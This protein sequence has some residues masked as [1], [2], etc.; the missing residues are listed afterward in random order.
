MRYKETREQ[1]SELL[2]MVLPQMARHSAGFH[3]MSYALWYEYLAGL[4][5]GLSAAVDARLAERNSFTDSDV[6][7][8]YERHVAQREAQTSATVSADIA[9][10]VQSVDGAATE[11]GKKVR[12]FGQELDGYRQQLQQEIG[13]EELTEVVRALIQDTTRVRDT[14][15]E[16]NDQ[17]KKSSQEVERLRVELEVAQGLACRDP[18][19]GLLNRRGFDQQLQR[20]W[21]AASGVSSLLI[22][23]IDQFKAI[24][25]AHGHLLGDKVIMAVARALHICASTHG[26]I[27]R[28][29]GEEFS[30]LLLQASAETA[31]S[32]AEQVRTAVERG[33][34][35]RAEAGDS[36]GGVTVSIGIASSLEGEQ[37]ESLM[38]RADRALYQSKAAGRNRITLAEAASVTGTDG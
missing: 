37:F 36:V 32:V 16:F 17:L 2:R 28:I 21:E 10:L 30:A 26:P 33:R 29:G 6:I 35:R 1:T 18:L 4:N 31:L 11:A 34:I 23:D 8:L 24:N 38:L 22:V 9:R 25:D 15:E 3:P 5:P 19:T 27:A 14:T 12:H 20:E 13:A 7:E